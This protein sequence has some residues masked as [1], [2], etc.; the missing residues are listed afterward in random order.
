M[1]PK[2]QTSFIPKK[3][4][5]SETGTSVGVV[6]ETNIFSVVATI[7]FIATILVSGGLFGYKIILHKQITAD[8]QQIDA[9]KAAL[10]VDKIKELIDANNR[11]IASKNLLDKHVA[12]SQLLTLMQSLT[13]R[14]IR[15]LDLTYL[16]KSGIAVLSLNGQAQ[17]YN[18]LA[19][20]SRIFSENEYLSNDKFS[21][22]TLEDNGYI[23]VKFEST[24]NTSLTSYK[25]AIEA[26]SPSEP[27]TPSQ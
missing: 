13:V 8:D 23:R 3:P 9:A 15:L 17:N 26:L 25:R 5:V 22:F 16:N 7:L 14:R 6:R 2:F 24:V 10:Q 1:E 19:E 18:A 11:I 20:Q 21:E 27:I 4:I 12:L